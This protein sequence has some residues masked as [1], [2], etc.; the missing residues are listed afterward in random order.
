MTADTARQKASSGARVH[1]ARLRGVVLAPALPLIVTYARRATQA[2]CSRYTAKA[3]RSR[4]NDSTA[5]PV[6]SKSPV[7]CR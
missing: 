4:A 1:G 5:P 3:G 2:R 7:I 6:K